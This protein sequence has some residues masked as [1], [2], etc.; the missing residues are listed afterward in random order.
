[1]I[2]QPKKNIIITH[3]VNPNQFYFKYLHDSVN[4]EYAKFDFDIQLYANNLQSKQSFENGY[5]PTENE[6]VIFCNVILNKW[7]R[8]R[9]IAIDEEITLWCIDNG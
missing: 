5:S 7:I 8:G 4:S 2:A 6:I 9:V 1:M 3:V